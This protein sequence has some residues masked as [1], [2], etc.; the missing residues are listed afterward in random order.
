MVHYNHQRQGIGKALLFEALE[1][2]ARRSSRD[3]LTFSIDLGGCEGKSWPFFNRHL[4]MCDKRNANGLPCY[5]VAPYE[6][7]SSDSGCCF[8]LHRSGVAQG[9]SC[10]MR[11]KVLGCSKT[12]PYLTLDPLDVVD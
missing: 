2:C 9:L 5:A 10:G 1:S 7:T 4:Q 8:N 3:S 11:Q 6:C 12:A